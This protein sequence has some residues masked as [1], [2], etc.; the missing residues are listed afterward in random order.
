MTWCKFSWHR[1]CFSILQK[2][3]QT[4]RFDKAKPRAMVG[5]KAT[6][7]QGSPG[8][9]DQIRN[10]YVLIKAVI[11]FLYWE[12]FM[13]DYPT[14]KLVS[15]LGQ[16]AQHV[17]WWRADEWIEHCRWKVHGTCS[18]K[19]RY[20]LI[21]IFRRREPWIVQ[22]YGICDLDWLVLEGR[23]FNLSWGIWIGKVAWDKI[24]LGNR[25]DEGR[26]NEGQWP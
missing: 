13:S 16:E 26:D 5:R 22:S 6:V 18:P 4:E 24:R 20:E 14:E 12:V 9:Q 21:I 3:T 17:N 1:N 19:A 10:G 23:S 7:L 8:C 11:R 15:I 2:T 25:K